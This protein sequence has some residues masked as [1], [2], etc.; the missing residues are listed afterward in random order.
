LNAAAWSSAVL[1][2]RDKDATLVILAADHVIHPVEVFAERIR[3]GFQITAD[4][5][6]TLI[7]FG[8]VPT[9]PLSG[10]GYLKLGDTLPGFPTA[11]QVLEFKE[12]PTAE[13]AQTYIADGGYWWNSGMF[14]WRADT[15]LAL[16][17]QLQPINAK[18]LRELTVTPQRTA[19]LYAQ[20]PANSIDY[21]VMEP[22]SRGITTA[23]IAAIGM[24]LEWRDVGSYAALRAALPQDGYGNAA[25]GQVM[26]TDCQGTLAINTAP[27]VLAVVGMSDVVAVRS[28]AATLLCPLADSER[29]KEIAGLLATQQP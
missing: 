23:H 26:F 17:D 22:V 19:Q 3:L 18:L 24:E 1:A 13:V 10:F 7:T 2:K 27:G 11:R 25:I 14:I 12:K 6:E 15:L 29:V 8:I 9:A 28:T 16:L 20:L 5:P 21:A 4:A